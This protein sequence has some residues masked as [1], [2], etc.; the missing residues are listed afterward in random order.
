MTPYII[1][2]TRN[3]Y[4]KNGIHTMVF[5]HALKTNLEDCFHWIDTINEAQGFFD[6]KET[7]MNEDKSFIVYTAQFATKEGERGW[8]EYEIWKE[9]DI[10][11]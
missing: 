5:S 2:S 4:V 3:T 9:E 7:Y 1:I 10:D 11:L 6:L 8:I